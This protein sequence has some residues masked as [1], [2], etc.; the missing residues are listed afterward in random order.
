MLIQGNDAVTECLRQDSN[1]I[2]RESWNGEGKSNDNTRNLPRESYQA[3]FTNGL[4]T[5]SWMTPF[6][7]E[8]NGRKYNLADGTYH[9]LLAKGP[10]TNGSKDNTFN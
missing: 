9:V 1:I 2:A 4:T 5:C 3:D 6:V 8:S 10:V 7:T